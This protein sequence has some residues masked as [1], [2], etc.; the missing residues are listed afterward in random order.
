MA[1]VKEDVKDG[2]SKTNAI[3]ETLQDHRWATPGMGNSTGA[4][5][6]GSL[7]SE[8]GGG[9][10]FVFCDGSVHFIPETIDPATF[11]ALCTIAGKENI[12][13]DY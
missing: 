9:A 3:G 6:N 4:P 10:Q 5:N 11:K 2:L 13:A 8:H 7:G 1:R 12:K